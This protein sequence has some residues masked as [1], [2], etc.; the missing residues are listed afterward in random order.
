MNEK[1]NW[2]E[3]SSAAFEK[4][5]REDKPVILDLTAVWCH[6]CH[7]MDATS[8]SDGEI[9]RAINK[10]FVPIKV[11][12]DK[13]PDIRDR[14]N[15]G[16]FPS[17]VF[18]T[19]D[20]YIVAGSTYV[21]P[22]RMKLLLESIKNTYKSRKE[23]LK[24]NTLENYEIIKKEKTTIKSKLN[25]DAI[26]EIL[27][28]VEDNFDNFYGGFGTQPKFPSPE[29]IDLLF[30]NYNKTNDKKYL[31]RAL[32]TLDGMYEGIYDKIDFGF[33]RYSVTQDWKMPHYEKMLDT[34][35]GLLRNYADAFKI[36]KNEKYK[37]ISL[38]II[39]YVNKFLSNRKTGGFYGSQD[40]DE[41][42]YNLN[43]KERKSKKYPYVDKTIY[44]DWNSMMISSY[45]KAGTILNDKSAVNFAV[46]TVE[47][48]LRNCYSNRNGLFHYFD[49]NAKI[50]G[51]FGDNIYFLNALLDDYTV[52]Q[53]DWHLERIKETADFLLANFYDETGQ[54][55]FD[56]IVKKDDLGILRQRQKQFLENSF[57]AMTFL[58]LY[59]TL[60]D[61]KYNNAAEKTL[62]YL[63]ESYL[64][65]GYFAS[66][67]AIALDIYLTSCASSSVHPSKS[68]P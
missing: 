63:A 61:Q 29:V 38:E 42:F 26:K 30:L 32:K 28:A 49:R 22:D 62:I 31:D 55:F 12:I 67:Y 48:L 13:R 11:D 68:F 52:T 51:L 7:V 57:A 33:F 27:L 45:I 8:Y 16:G 6:W 66:M 10:D 9:I 44:V 58:R 36:T 40:A 60:K 3:W 46:R 5:K 21:P 37:K 47:F 18:L 64:N 34:N 39:D 20:G 25:K 35:A 43:E 4:A 41:E 23:E 53:N 56:R 14:F 50:N 17:T 19:A 2:L 15:M 54:G 65:Y 24:K 1:I 59:L